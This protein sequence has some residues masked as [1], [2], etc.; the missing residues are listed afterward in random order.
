MHRAK[1]GRF[2]TFQFMPS[3]N[4]L[5]AAHAPLL[6]L[7]AAST[8]IQVGWLA[9]GSAHWAASFAEAG[10]GLFECLDQLQTRPEAA[11]AF[12]FCDGPGSILGVRTVAMMLRAWLVLRSRP[13]FAYHSLLLLAHARRDPALTVIAD[14]R[15]DSWHCAA[16]GAPLRRVP[17]AELPVRLAMPEGFRTWSTAPADLERIPY[18]LA[19]LLPATHDADIFRAIDEP[20]AFLHEEPS[21]ATWSPQ[22]HRAP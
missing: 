1:A 17:T 4:Q 18:S 6:V 10:I 20:D 8:R 3:L 5:L 11:G 7:D 12:V 9:P 22:I 15:R 13:V 14:A 2:V 19:E 21:Y 16:I